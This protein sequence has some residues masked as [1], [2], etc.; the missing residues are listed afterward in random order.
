[1]TAKSSKTQTKKRV[2]T[3]PAAKPTTRKSTKAQTQADNKVSQRLKAAKELQKN[4]EKKA[5]PEHVVN[6]IND[7]L[8]LFGLVITIYLAIS[9]AS[10]SMDDPAWSRSVPKSSDVANLGG[11]FGSYLSDVGYYL[12][13]LSFWWWIAASCVF[14][15][16]NFRPMKKQENHKPYN[17]GVA[18][19]ALFLLLVCS[20]II[21]HFLFDN[22]LS[23]SL[24][25]GAGGLVGLLAGSG[26]AWLLGKSSSL[27]IMLVML[28]LSISLLA[29]VS[30]LEV[31]T[32][33][34]SHM[35]G[36]FGNLMK[37]LSQFQNKKE[38]IRTE[39]LETQNTRRMV[40]EAKTI[41]ATPVAPLA[42]SSS[43]RKTVAVSVA[44]PPKIQTSLFDD[45][46]PKNNGEYH[47]PNMNLLRMPSEEPVAVNPDELQQTAELIEAKL[48]EF[49]IGVQ[50]VSAT[51]GPVITR[52]EIEP[53]QGVKG[54]QIVALSK[55]LAR[56]MSL[57][58]VR[59]VETIA[60]KNTMGIELPNEKRQ[61]VMLSEIL[62]SPVFTDAKSKLTVALGKD[63]AGTPV[64]GDLAKM[65]HLLVAGMT[66]SGKSVGVNGMI[67]SMLFKASP[68]EVRFIM[69]DPKMLE[70]S[71]YDGIP[72]L[73]CPV[74]T[75]MREAGQALNWCVA[76]M[77]KRYRLLSH[78][79]VRN[80]DGFNQKVEDAKAAGEPLL[81]PFSL[82]PDD[83]EPLEKLP[84]IVV[85]IDE[86][87]DLMMTERKSVE[88]QIARL[89]QKARAAGIHMI[90]ATQRPSVD[91]V[92]GLIKANIPTRMAF[93]VQSKIDSRTILDQMGA[94]ELLKYGDSLFLQPGSAEPTR[95]Q[96][97]F[98]SDDEV[99]QVV[100]FVKEQAPTNYVEGLL[101]GEAAIETTN[102]VNP[103]AN[104]D[105]LFD[106]AVAFV[107][108]SRKTSISA[109]QRQ[110][111]IGYNRAANLVDALENAGVLSPA[112]I[113]GSRRILAQ[114]DQ[115]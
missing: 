54:S 71:I 112:D 91:V 79:G 93:T 8:W 73:L 113:N 78:A 6:L 30:W 22:A 107:L 69:I 74:V 47:K 66:G 77:E 44:P 102:I 48:A 98:V 87:A 90:V 53:A 72:H 41:T 52:Y 81:N 62:S 23:E 21:E 65:P 96:G 5:R 36:L 32:K 29:Q 37:K 104:S 111:R 35:G 63:I 75:D 103:N 105:E 45:T 28:L 19:L 70:L 18:A 101:S 13:G 4:E 86:L 114:K 39:A 64:V 51:S 43:N 17:H 106:Q 27:L 25:V 115:L 26:L 99:H 97:A 33:S 12:F 16:K 38:D 109:L 84:L 31:M 108:E 1:M 55:D 50:V 14:L 82:N 92:T 94:D 2:S 15:Y 61:D 49:G 9:L 68:D 80:L 20:P 67:M 58:A 7:A 95:L 46:E 110:L 42:G 89:A 83:P 3:K 10:F 11:L 76:E 24:P 59:I 88:Q 57:Q 34:G 60:G 40:K 100:N 85:V 56:S